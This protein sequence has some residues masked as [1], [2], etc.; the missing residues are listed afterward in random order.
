MTIGSWAC[1]NR[2]MSLDTVMTDCHDRGTSQ[3]S[4]S[5][6]KGYKGCHDE[7]RTRNSGCHNKKT[8]VATAMTRNKVQRL[9]W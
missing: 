8:N 5:I 9:Q 2:K 6:K 1:H 3:D 7:S 4:A